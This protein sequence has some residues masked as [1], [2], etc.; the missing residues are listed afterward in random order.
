[1]A[2]QIQNPVHPESAAHLM[3]PLSELVSLQVTCCRGR[4]LLQRVNHLCWDDSA[5]G[6]FPLLSGCASKCVTCL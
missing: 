4:V 5:S 1:M 6:G 2:M 3:Y